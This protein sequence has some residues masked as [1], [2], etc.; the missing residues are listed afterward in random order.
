MRKAVPIVGAA[1]LLSI[2]LFSIVDQD[3]GGLRNSAQK[4]EKG[5][6]IFE[7]LSFACWPLTRLKA[8]YLTALTICWNA[9]GL[10]IARSARTLRFRAIPDLLSL[11]INC[12]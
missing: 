8:A 5:A 11:P 2:L 9:S 12:E 7:R 4:K 1:F 3:S 10:F 6:R